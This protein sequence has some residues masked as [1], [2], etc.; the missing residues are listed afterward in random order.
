MWLSK[1]ISKASPA[2][3]AE[4]GSI[5]ISGTG[6]VEA[7]ASSS[8]QKLI[9]YTPYGY[10]ANVP[11]GE[12]VAVIPS[13]DGSIALGTACKSQSLESGEILITSKG[14]AIIMLKNNGSVIIN[15]L[16]IDK[17]GVIHSG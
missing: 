8:A 13:S 10:C 7:R 9:N 15:S 5:T 16:E 2:A 3:V 11:V 12:E 1:M 17:N 14:G 4:K 6:D